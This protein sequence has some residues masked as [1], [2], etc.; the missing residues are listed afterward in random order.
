LLI[1]GEGH[2]VLIRALEPVEGLEHM[3]ELRGVKRADKGEGLKVTDLCSGPSKLTQALGISRAEFDQRD[4]VDCVDLWV[5]EGSLGDDVQV[6][7]CARIGIEKSE[8]WAEKPLR[9]YIKGSP[10]VSVINK[11][12]EA[13]LASQ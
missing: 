10:S 13:M 7:A 8:E 1:A 2:A 3:R 9:F 11:N 12:A 5:E 4:L 6:V